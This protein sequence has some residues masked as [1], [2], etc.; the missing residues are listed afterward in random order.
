MGK[1]GFEAHYAALFGSRWPDLKRALSS[2]PLY[3][4]LDFSSMDAACQPYFIDAASVCAALCL[5]LPEDGNVL[6]L[7]A[8][9]GGKSLVLAGGLGAE[10]LLYSNELSPDRK[11]RLDKVLSASLPAGM[12]QKVITSCGDGA[13]WCR[14]ET[15]AFASV[16]L[17][18]PCSSERHVLGDENYLAQWSASRIKSL[19]ARQWALLSSAWRLLQRGGN[20]LYATCALSSDEN[21]GVLLRLFKRFPDVRRV[22][23][24]EL[25]GIFERNLAAFSGKITVPSGGTAGSLLMNAFQTAQETEKGLH[26]LPDSGAGAGP[27]YFSLL[28]KEA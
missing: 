6:D 2:D 9:P 1:D 5:P 20:L 27:L 19:A 21:D 15:E 17:D 8:A 16:L 11:A 18:A 12:R 26:I 7:C 10:S 24:S 13:V 14:R 23:P 3:L 28:R 22:E 4:Q 25:A